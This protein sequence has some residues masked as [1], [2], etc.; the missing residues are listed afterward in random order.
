MPAGAGGQAPAPRCAALPSSPRIDSCIT[1][2]CEHRSGEEARLH[3]V[4]CSEQF[5]E[6]EPGGYNGGEI[7]AAGIERGA[8]S[9]RSA[10]LE[11]AAAA[12]ELSSAADTAGAGVHAHA[13]GA[14][15]GQEAAAL[16]VEQGGGGRAASLRR[17]GSAPRGHMLADR[18]ATGLDRTA[19]A[20]ATSQRDAS[21]W[22]AS[23]WTQFSTLFVRA[24]RVRRFETL[25]KQ[26]QSGGVG[27]G[28]LRWKSCEHA[29][30]WCGGGGRWR[31]VA[32]AV[33][34]AWSPPQDLVQL[35]TVGLVC[36][37]IWWQV[38]PWPGA[39]VAACACACIRRA[40]APAQAGPE[41]RTPPCPPR[42]LP[43]PSPCIRPTHRGAGGS[44]RHA[45][46]GAE[47]ARPAVLRSTIRLLP[48]P[49][50]R[51]LCVAQ[52]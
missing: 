43:T 48:H 20:L 15:H 35:V 28:G 10:S 7:D 39:C 30:M 11:L 37:C 31:R 18:A 1:T 13:N 42:A 5:L 14:R 34:T 16:D 9:R 45:V 27:R 23:Y 6:Q 51:A 26:V 17:K 29:N 38:R 8:S 25:S 12:L 36:G 52:R 49:L 21:R 41:H 2:P 40:A 22:G 44:E 4:A 3:L 19:T 46:C 24:V 33:Q 32:S 50:C 47:H